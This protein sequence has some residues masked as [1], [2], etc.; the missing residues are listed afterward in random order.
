MGK[1]RLFDRIKTKNGFGIHSPFVF[2]LQTEILNSNHSY[3][4]FKELKEKREVFLKFERAG[5]IIYSEEYYQ[6]LFRMENFFQHKSFI[7][8]GNSSGL[9]LLSLITPTLKISMSYLYNPFMNVDVLK[10]LFRESTKISWY[11]SFFEFFNHLSKLDTV[12]V[13]LVSDFT[14]EHITIWELFNLC[15]PKFHNNS[16]LIVEGLH[17]SDKINHFWNA[18]NSVDCI[19]TM[20]DFQYFGLVFFNQQSHKKIY[21]SY[22]GTIGDLLNLKM[23]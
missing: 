8:F 22:I 19:S 20:I 23:R 6:A 17:Q 3:Y 9:S 10:I 4:A 15:L 13:L 14:N 5:C 21:N 18:L 11:N 7:S 16:F 12:D 1:E 2:Y